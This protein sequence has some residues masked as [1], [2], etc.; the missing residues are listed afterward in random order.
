MTAKIHEILKAGPPTR[1]SRCKFCVWLEHL[2]EEDRLAIR[3]AHDSGTWPMSHLSDLLISQGF[4]GSSA[5]VR[6][7]FVKKH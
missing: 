2:T 3:D 4:E 5:T 6:T 7:H 1:D